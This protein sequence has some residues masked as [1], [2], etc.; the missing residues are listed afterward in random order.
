[1]SSQPKRKTSRL[2]RCTGC[3]ACR[4]RKKK[5]DERK[6]VC[7]ACERNPLIC[8][9]LSATSRLKA[10]PSPYAT[11]AYEHCALGLRGLKHR[12]TKLS[13]GDHDLALETL[14]TTLVFCFIEVIRGDDNG[15]AF[16]HLKAARHILSGIFNGMYHTPVPDTSILGFITEFYAY[17]LSSS[18][19]SVVNGPDPSVIQDVET[20]CTVMDTANVPT[21]G[22]LFGCARELF[23]LIPAVVFE[24][25]KLGRMISV[26]MSFL[27]QQ[28]GD[29]LRQKIQAWQPDIRSEKQHA[30]GGNLYQQ[31]MLLLLARPG[32]HICYLQ[33]SSSCFIASPSEPKWQLFSAGLWLWWASGLASRL[34]K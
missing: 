26:S 12:L 22:T 30:I 16:Y 14:V 23:R 2:S 33:T 11:T 15:S 17:I 19:S 6:P 32:D 4:Q 8:T 10:Q 34:I 1:M 3:L 21:H 13:T 28:A 20:V 29:E 9:Y 25:D 24:S 7:L 31:A 18:S 27:E 5:Y